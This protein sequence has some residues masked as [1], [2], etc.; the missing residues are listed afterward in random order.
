MR[1]RDFMALLGGAAAGWPRLGHEQQSDR[2]SERQQPNRS[3]LPD[4]P[5]SISTVPRCST[6]TA[7][8]VTWSSALTNRTGFG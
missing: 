3:P 6:S 2:L 5:T 7:L 1:R 4:M 8:I